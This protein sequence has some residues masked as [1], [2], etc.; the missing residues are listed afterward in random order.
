MTGVT[1][2]PAPLFKRGKE[3][4]SLPSLQEIFNEGPVAL[5]MQMLPEQNYA[6][7]EPAW[8]SD[9]GLKDLVSNP[10]VTLSIAC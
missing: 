4:L 9:K 3:W 10:N 2:L 5:I 8:C 1:N 6:A 7:E